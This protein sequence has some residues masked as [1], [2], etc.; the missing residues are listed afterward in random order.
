MTG[1]GINIKELKDATEN[2]DVQLFL[3]LASEKEI[4][5][6][7]KIVKVAGVEGSFRLGV[8]VFPDSAAEILISQ[9]ITKR[10]REIMEELRSSLS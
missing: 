6:Y 2:A 5:L 1:M 4:K 3:K 7:G 9:Y 8:K 10:Q